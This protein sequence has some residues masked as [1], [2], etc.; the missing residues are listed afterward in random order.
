AVRCIRGFAEEIT[1][2]EFAGEHSLV[3]ASGSSIFVY[4]QRK[5]DLISHAV[6]SA[7]SSFASNG[8]GEVQALS[9]R[10]D[11]VA[12]V[13]DDGCL[14]VCDITDDSLSS[15]TVVPFS[16]GHD[17][18][19][20]CVCMH[21]D[22]PVVASGGFDSKVLLWDMASETTTK[23]FVAD[24]SNTVHDTET[25]RQLVNP[26]F[27][28]TLDFVPGADDGHALQFVSGHADGRLMCVG[29]ETTFSWSSCH[30]Y[31]ISALRFM[32]A[33]PEILATASLDCTLALWD[34]ESVVSPDVAVD[35][36]AAAECMTAALVLGDRP[37]LLVQVELDA[38]PDTLASSETAPVI[39]IDQGRDVIAYTIA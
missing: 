10:G 13:D 17:A 20:G 34:A 3:A 33:K 4:D 36:N 18:L 28:Y 15:N 12:F 19:A 37:C 16:G 5:L 11:F 26:P 7:T 29:G 2:V 38:K 30:G 22:E 9:A 24:A 1:A 21:P 14:A 23:T 39:Y 8:G 31:S 25:G 32:R 35:A 27:V 6:D